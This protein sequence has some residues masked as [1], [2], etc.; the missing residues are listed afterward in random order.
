M[1]I[2]K[3]KVNGKT[4]E[5]K[6]LS[7]TETEPLVVENKKAEAPKETP[8]AVAT[9]APK[10]EEVTDGIQVNSPM[11]GTILNINV[12]V[13]DNVHSGDNLLILEAM[14]LENEIKAPQDGK[15]LSIAV[16]KGAAVNAGDLLIVLG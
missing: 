13:G 5:V 12:K 1:R 4:Y 16:N 14:K 6:I 8:I 2:Y 15:I 7:V 10:K 11:Q 3:I 9:E